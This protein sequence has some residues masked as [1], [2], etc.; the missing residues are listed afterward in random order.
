MS[1]SIVP[2]QSPFSKSPLLKGPGLLERTKL[3]ERAQRPS[4]LYSSW[5]PETTC[6]VQIASAAISQPTARPYA[7][8]GHPMYALL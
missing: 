7:P 3:A 6:A 2:A 1:T 8:R 4:I 5:L